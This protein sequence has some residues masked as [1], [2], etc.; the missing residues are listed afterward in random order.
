MPA[1]AHFGDGYEATKLGCKLSR[2]FM[3]EI[4]DEMC[5][6]EVAHH[7]NG[8]PE[9]FCSRPE[10]WV[11][12]YKKGLAISGASATGKGAKHTA[13]GQTEDS[14]ATGPGGSRP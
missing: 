13:T 12:L 5:Q 8:C 2:A 11:H 9:Y 14:T 7:A 4:G 6:S 10:K 1:R 3:A